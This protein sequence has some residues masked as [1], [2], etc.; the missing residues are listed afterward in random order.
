VTD[1]GTCGGTD[2]GTDSCIAVSGA[3]VGSAVGKSECGCGGECE[4]DEFIFH[5][6]LM[7]L[8]LIGVDYLGRVGGMA[9]RDHGHPPLLIY[10]I[11]DLAQ[12]LFKNS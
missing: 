10:V 11:D 7:N 8:L 12:G 2:T 3:G 6:L 4:C 5:G 9:D 1:D